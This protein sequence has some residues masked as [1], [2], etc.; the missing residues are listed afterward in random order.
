MS[1]YIFV[2]HQLPNSLIY[3]RLLFQNNSLHLSDLVILSMIDVATLTSGTIISSWFSVKT[4]WQV[5][6][7][8]IW[9]TP[10]AIPHQLLL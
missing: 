2:L 5:S 8:Q 4:L 3:Q 1:H 10:H 6:S 7:T 9:S